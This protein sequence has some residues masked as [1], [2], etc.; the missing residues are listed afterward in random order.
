MSNNS[1]KYKFLFCIFLLIETNVIKAQNTDY[2]QV[3][4]ID[5]NSL[6]ILNSNFN[7]DSFILVNNQNYYSFIS[8]V[9]YSTSN[10]KIQ[11][12]Y[13]IS[14]SLL[15]DPTKNSSFPVNLSNIQTKSNIF[16]DQF[17]ATKQLYFSI[18]GNDYLNNE[19]EF[20]IFK[21]NISNINNIFIRKI[22][23]NCSLTLITCI[24]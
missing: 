5:H 10:S 22:I 12:L 24:F 11:T 7:L 9:N 8:K 20:I 16:N 6:P 15:Y 4:Q 1:I 23:F 19:L 18:S 21:F 14:D 17:R 2:C 3:S 13:S